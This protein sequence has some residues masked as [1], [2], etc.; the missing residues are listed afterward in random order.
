MFGKRL[1]RS[2]CSAIDGLI[3]QLR[4]NSRFHISILEGEAHGFVPA[5]HR[6]QSAQDN[7][8]DTRFSEKQ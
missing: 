4:K 8:D 2:G 7:P 5:I 3:L 1:C 6:I